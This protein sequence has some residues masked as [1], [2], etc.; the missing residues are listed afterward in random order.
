MK[1][2]SSK[3]FFEKRLDSGAFFDSQYIVNKLT[4]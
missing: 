2:S 4:Y 1:N 3:R